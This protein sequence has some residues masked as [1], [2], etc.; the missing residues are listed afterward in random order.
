VVN[1]CKPLV[2]VEAA[3]VQQPLVQM[4]WGLLEAMAVLA[5]PSPSQAPPSHTLGEVGVQASTPQAQG[6]Q[7]EGALEAHSLQ[8]LPLVLPILVVVAVGIIQLEHQVAPAL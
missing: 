1:C 2:V 7:G 4:V 6:V 3:G 5:S 8:L